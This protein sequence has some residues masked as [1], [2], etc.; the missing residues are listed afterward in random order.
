L[1]FELH[2]YQKYAVEF[3]KQHKQSALILDMGLGKTAITLH[4]LTDLL[5]D[6]FEVQRVLVI[7]PLR[8]AST[9]WGQEV[10]KWGLPIRVEHVLGT[11]KDRRRA[12]QRKANL[13]LINREN[14]PWLVK[15]GYFDFDC[16]VI[17]ELSSFKSHQ[18]ARF[19]SLWQVRPTV[20][21]VIGLTGTPASN[22]LMDLFAE[23]KLLDLGE[24]LGRYIGRYRE[25]YFAPDKR[26][27]S[28]IFSY[29]PREGSEDLI[30][31]KIAD[32]T[33]SMRASDYLRL[34]P[35]TE[36]TQNAVLAEDEMKAYNALK[37]ELYTAHKGEEITAANA[38]VLA[39][40]L[41]QY[42]NG[43]I[44][45]DGGGVL[46]LH[47]RKFDVLEDLIEQACGKPVLI[48]YWFKHDFARIKKRFP[49]AVDLRTPESIDEWNAQKLPIACIHPASAGHGLNLQSGGSTLIW[50]GLTWSLELYQ[51][52]NARLYRQGQGQAVVIHHIVSV[53]TIDEKILKALGDKDKIQSALIDAVKAEAAN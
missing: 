35:L 26:N 37:S 39:G 30:Y 2:E 38:A 53:G 24:R 7:A 47:S 9:V 13:Y 29:K 3:I 51:Q 31:D 41:A 6:T 21:R 5:F 10:R 1:N 11:E 46:E 36:T 20:K 40:K 50:F 48:A 12:L 19:K 27:G 16:V 17:D 15:S 18:S 44:Y 32:I 14:V 23:Y 28:Q 45:T 22:G 49:T 33:V 8:V 42:A 52:T 43:A 34:P 25:A 4:A